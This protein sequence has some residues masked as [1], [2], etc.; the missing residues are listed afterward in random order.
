MMN[1][2]NEKKIAQT[3]LRMYRRQLVTTDDLFDFKKQLI[4]EAKNLLKEQQGTPTK[5]G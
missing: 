3:E 2:K 1:V 4:F 5:N